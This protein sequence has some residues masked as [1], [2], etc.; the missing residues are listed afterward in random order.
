MA[1]KSKFR[2]VQ[3]KSKLAQK[4]LAGPS[5]SRQCEFGCGKYFET[6]N[7]MKI[8]Q[9]RYCK[10]K[11]TEKSKAILRKNIRCEYGCGQHFETLAGM[12]IHQTRYCKLKVK[13]TQTTKASIPIELSTS[14]EI[15]AE[16]EQSKAI[17]RRSNH[18]TN[19]GSSQACR[20]CQQLILTKNLKT[21]EGRD[22]L[23]LKRILSGR[24]NKRKHDQ[25][26]SDYQDQSEKIIRQKLTCEFCLKQFG[27]SGSLTRHLTKGE[28]L[29]A[30]HTQLKALYPDLVKCPSCK[31]NFNNNKN[32]VA[33]FRNKIC[34][35]I[36]SGSAR[37]WVEN[38]VKSLP[39]RQINLNQAD[40]TIPD[41][42]SENYPNCEHCGTKFVKQVAYNY[43]KT[44]CSKN[45]E[46]VQSENRLGNKSRLDAVSQVDLSTNVNQE[47]SENQKI[48][49]DESGGYPLGTED[50]EDEDSP[51]AQ[52]IIKDMELEPEIRGTTEVID[53]DTLEQKLTKLIAKNK[54]EL[55]TVETETNNKS[56]I[57]NFPASVHQTKSSSKV[58]TLQECCFDKCNSCFESEQLRKDHELVCEFSDVINLDISDEESEVSSRSS[59]TRQ[60]MNPEEI[61]QIDISTESNDNN[62]KNSGDTSNT[63]KYHSENSSS[64]K[65]QRL[66]DTINVRMRS[67]IDS[68]P[69]DLFENS[70]NSEQLGSSPN[71]Y[72]CGFCETEFREKEDFRRHYQVDPKMW[73]ENTPFN[74]NIL[75]N[76]KTPGGLK[77]TLV[78]QISL[79]PYH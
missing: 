62:V 5:E 61:E 51:A 72:K 29:V 18:H 68:L 40:H 59:L 35:R 7:G 15:V 16:A 63:R 9:G 2:F 25:A 20:F 52:E 79:F 10:L 4:L 14:A 19:R 65:R 49:E 24:K 78:H 54:T 1:K 75:C 39:V 50:E 47:I 32:F 67:V 36:D 56:V 28:C 13:N 77:K 34:K 44:V 11:E 71:M 41:K 26:Q 74:R 45:P 55:N 42:N 12:K 33:H 30:S 58:I 22:C 23:E 27:N 46:R 70:E 38:S 73:P 43:H 53:S 37:G 64:A 31:K 6:L 60:D 21:H 48:E 76:F 57:T 3:K 69:N 8:H 17:S 66:K